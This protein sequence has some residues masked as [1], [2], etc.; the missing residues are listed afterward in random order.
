MS[1]FFGSLAASSF[2][3]ITMMGYVT[4]KR[5][6]VRKLACEDFTAHSDTVCQLFDF[7]LISDSTVK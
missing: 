4:Y 2:H 3:Y 7:S 5:N 6:S 1:Y